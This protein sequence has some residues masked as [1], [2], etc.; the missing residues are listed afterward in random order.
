[1]EPDFRSPHGRA[2]LA[3]LPPESPGACGQEQSD[4]ILTAM[5]TRLKV[6][7][8]LHLPSQHEAF[9]L[10]L[11]P[12]SSLF[13]PERQKSEVQRQ[14]LDFHYTGRR[15]INPSVHLTDNVTSH[16]QEPKQG[17]TQQGTTA[18]TGLFLRH[19]PASLSIFSPCMTLTS[20]ETPSSTALGKFKLLIKLNYSWKQFLNYSPR[21]L[22]RARTLHLQVL[23]ARLSPPKPNYQRSW[24]QGVCAER[25]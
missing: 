5:T 18:L 14:I 3:V 19:L 16:K 23:I 22:A 10:G 12:L 24:C 2:H 7:F 6:A 13:F 8:I 11:P 21:L 25:C 17:E 9:L 15:K 4:L 20:T 1:M